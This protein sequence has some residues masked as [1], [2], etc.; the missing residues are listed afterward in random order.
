ME[1]PTGRIE[2]HPI[3]DGFKDQ[4]DPTDRRLQALQRRILGLRKIG[5]ALLAV[6]KGSLLTLVDGVS[7][8]S[9]KISR[10]TGW[11]TSFAQG[12]LSSSFRLSYPLAYSFFLSLLNPILWTQCLAS[13]RAM[14]SSTN[15][16]VSGE[17]G[18]VPAWGVSFN[19]SFIFY[20]S[21][22]LDIFT[23]FITTEKH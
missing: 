14:K 12:H 1:G 9:L 13:M 7:R 22:D 4:A 10:I 11:T 21:F 18:L 17:S 16:R 19:T 23:F 3:I 20:C 2:P 5:V 15:C 6:I 8:M